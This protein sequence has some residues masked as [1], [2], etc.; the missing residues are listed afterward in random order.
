MKW[1]ES[2][3][4]FLLWGVFILPLFVGLATGVA[5]SDNS[6]CFGCHQ[7]ESLKKEDARGKSISLFVSEAGYKG[8]VHGSLSCSDCHT[9]IK[10]D[11]HAAGGR[12][13]QIER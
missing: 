2:G 12:R 5:W 4:S 1:R 7:D 11:A 3:F 9:H 6:L 13:P 10:D 8:S